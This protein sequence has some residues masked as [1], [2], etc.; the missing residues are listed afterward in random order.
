MAKN[1]LLSNEISLNRKLKEA[2]LAFRI[3]RALSKERILE[4]YL[5]DIYLGY[6]SYGIGTASLN[7]F[8]KSIYDLEL[9][10]IAFL[11]ALPKAPNN[12]NPKTN[13]LKAIER[14]NWVIDRMYQNGF[15]KEEDLI[16]K[17]K[18]LQVFERNDIKFSAADYF[19]EEIRKE[20]YSKF[21]KEKLYS[22]GLIIKTALD[23]EIQKN[24]NLSLIEGLIEYEKN[25]GWHGLIDNTNLDNFF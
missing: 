2:I 12:Y 17:N 15:I 11:A 6:G 18:P 25:Q 5:N 23:S 8:N 20:L 3:E 21:G 7:Y 9:H 4:L 1:F 22:Y 19:Y 13:Y 14:R 16:Y 24:A 10:E